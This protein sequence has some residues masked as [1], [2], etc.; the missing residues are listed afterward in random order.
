MPLA[1]INGQRI[2]FEDSG[3]SGPPVVLA[4]GFLMDQSMFSPQVEALGAAFR[5]IRWDERCFGN[6]QEDGRPFTYWDSAAD[7]IGLLDHLG[8]NEAVI[9]GMSQ[10]GFLALRAALAHPKRVK[11]LV[12]ISTQAGVDPPETIAGYRQMMAQW[13]ALGPIEPL[14]EAIAGIILGGPEHWEP[15]ISRW[16][17]I[18]AERLRAA[19]ECL[20]SRDDLTGRLG[21]ITCPAILFH[22]DADQAIPLARSEALRDGLRGC[23]DF[24]VVKGAAHAANVTHPD[25][26]NPKLGDFL[27]AYA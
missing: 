18:P 25:Q 21:E 26:V 8:I 12:L 4:H 17:T 3:G 24:V 15:W 5:L 11:G 22:G 6:T 16:K 27:R 23:K 13:E 7:C 10:G 14:V 1:T 19:N 2:Y 9:G 20:L